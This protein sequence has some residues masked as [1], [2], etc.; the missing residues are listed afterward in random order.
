MNSDLMSGL[1]LWPQIPQLDFMLE[2]LEF[3]TNSSL[4]M[5]S[6]LINVPFSYFS[7]IMCLFCLVNHHS[8]LWNLLTSD[9]RQ[10]GHEEFFKILPALFFKADNVGI[11]HQC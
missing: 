5:H 11:D 4:K 2:L 1:C 9:V 6:S 7:L 10:E 8:L 3:T